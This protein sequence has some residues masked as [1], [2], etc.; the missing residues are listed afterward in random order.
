MEYDYI[1]IGSGFGGSVSALRL[2]QKGYKVLVIEKGKW[3]QAKDFPKTNWN[4]R[5]WLWV[6]Y[7]R[8]FGIMKLSVFKHIAIISGTGVGGGS[9]VYANT[10]PTPKTTFFNSGSWKE[11][12][13]WETELQP[14]YDTALQML[15]ATKNPKLFDGDLGLHKVAKDLNIKEKFDATRVAVFF[16]E[17]DVT[18]KDP[19]F[20]GK[21]P[22]RAGCN[23]C[24]ACMTGCRYNAKNTLDKNYLYLAQKNGAEIRAENEVI[25][26]QPIN[27]ADG[28]QGYQ[29]SIKSSTKL[30]AKRKI[31]KTKGV[32]FSG[33]VLGTV[34]LLLK[35]KMK[36]LPHLSDKLG[37]D[38]RSNNETLI[39]VS[40]LEKDKNYSKG[41]AIGSILHT[42]ENSHLE[43]CRYGE[44]SDA[45]KLAHLPYVT[46]SNVTSRIFKTIGKLFKHPVDYFKIY[47]VNGWAKNT[48]VLLFMQ[49]LDST[50]K[51]KRNAI[52]QM[53]S[54]V[55]T[56]KAPTPFIPESIQLVKAYSKAIKGVS[57]SFALETLA[58]I[59]STAHILGGAVMGKDS[60]TGV[61]DKD[62]KVFGYI[63]ML[64]I[65]GAMISANPG[66]NP[67]LTITAIA[68]KAMGEI[69]NK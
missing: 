28:S 49:T 66:V 30:F 6:P 5:K 40:G 14:H 37:E 64:V 12:N 4:F 39:S 46:G 7:L 56:G 33:G 61:I 34:K 10:L 65:D 29:V 20:K 2:S 62:N 57:T 44:G 36:S 53:S 60:T 38:I 51:F 35:L 54:T 23:F 19:Y 47:F 45:W 41:I 43:I 42:D 31:I 63:N 3:Y 32:I 52:G 13:D 16:G 9:L 17:P 15:G 22:E 27:A 8:F 69:P 1:I 21:G 55:S 24:G 67:S 58:G 25:D 50:L 18:V 48:V 11:L 59:P 26:V 68:E